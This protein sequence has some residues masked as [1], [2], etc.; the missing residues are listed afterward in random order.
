MHDLSKRRV[1]FAPLGARLYWLPDNPDM[2]YLDSPGLQSSD[3][4]NPLNWVDCSTDVLLVVAV[5]GCPP[6]LGP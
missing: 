2:S 3:L 4:S 6:A 5:Q 1:E